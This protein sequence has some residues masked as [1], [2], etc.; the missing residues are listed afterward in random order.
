MDRLV[1]IN[2]NDTGSGNNSVFSNVKIYEGSCSQSVL[3]ESLL[4]EARSVSPVFGDE[5]ERDLVGTYITP[6]PT[7]DNFSIYLSKY[8]TRNVIAHIYTILGSKKGEVTLQPGVNTLSGR[9]LSLESGIYLIKIENSL[10]ESTTHK[11]II[12]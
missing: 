5:E 2:D 10:G 9:N 6:N 12:N 11:L 1:F 4:A 3:A 8:L 7:R